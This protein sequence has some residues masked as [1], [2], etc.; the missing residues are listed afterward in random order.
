MSTGTLSEPEQKSPEPVRR[1]VRARRGSKVGVSMLAHGEPMIWLTGAALAICL[2]M[3]VG[4]LGTVI[5]L[6]MGTFTP[7]PVVQLQH[8]DG[9]LIAGEVT[10]REQFPITADLILGQ[11]DKVAGDFLVELVDQLGGAEAV[12]RQLP[13]W[14]AQSQTEMREQIAEFETKVVAVQELIQRNQA[15]IQKRVRDVPNGNGRLQDRLTIIAASREDKKQIGFRNELQALRSKISSLEGQIKNADQ[16]LEYIKT[17]SETPPAE[18]GE[19]A[20]GPLQNLWQ[21]P[22]Q[23][24]VVMLGALLGARARQL[25]RKDVQG[26]RRLVR[27]GNKELS[28]ATFR[29]VMD[30]EIEPEESTEPEWSL[31][32]ERKAWGRF[33]G[34]PQQFVI[35]ELR[36]VGAAEQELQE[37]VQLFE[38]GM[39]DLEPKEQEQLQEPLQGLRDELAA[40]QSKQIKEFL[41]RF[42]GSEGEQLLAVPHLGAPLPVD[43]LQPDTTVVEVRRIW[44]GAAESW[45]RFSDTHGEVLDRSARRHAL[46]KHDSGLVSRRRQDARLALRTQELEID[47]QLKPIYHEKKRVERDLQRLKQDAKSASSAQVAALQQQY[48]ELSEQARQIEA[49]AVN[50]VGVTEEVRQYENLRQ[51]MQAQRD[52]NNAL[53]E[54]VN[55]KFGEDSAMSQA[56]AAIV[57]RRNEDIETAMMDPQAK[58]D[59]LRS[60]L[61]RAPQAAQETIEEF[62]VIQKEADKEN[63]AIQREI[64]LITA[65]NERYELHMLTAD[66]KEKAL[67]LDDI[68]RAY[69][70]NQLNT[71]EKAAVYA[72]RW[73]EFLTADPREANSEGGVFPAIWGTIIMT[74]IMSLAV[75]PFGVLAALYLREYAKAGPIVSAVRISINNLAGVPSIVFGVFGLGFFCYIVGAYV[76]GGPDN[77]VFGSAPSPLWYTFLAALAVVAFVAFACGIGGMAA[78]H[79]QRTVTKIW[80]S[81]ISVLLWL[82]ATALFVLVIATTPFF[83]GFYETQLPNPKFGKGGVFW[84]SLT[85]ALLTLPVVIVATEEALAAVPNSMREGSYGCGASKWQTIRR[86]VLPHA[87]P[88][89]MTGMILAMARG[90]GEV[91]PLMLVG[92][93]KLAP[94]LPIHLA[95]W[96]GSIGP[97]LTGPL[98]ADRSFMHLGFHIFDLGFQSQ[99]S[100]AAKPMVFTTTLLLI[101]IIAL[102]NLGAVWLRNRLR[103]RFQ[104][105]QF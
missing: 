74:L 47:H 99:D 13:Q 38:R 82:V 83:S 101:L 32:V 75:A 41:A 15:E 24:K 55:D 64:D 10:N 76:D 49:N 71:A 93:V 78:H 53:G 62:F 68:V 90:A 67:V 50:L 48:K 59:Q 16:A 73:W 34:Q 11:S 105:G 96:S 61:A 52:R 97:V 25:E 42:D 9:Y 104:E 5:W 27:I 89:I 14:I 39:A 81:R 20:L 58:L 92:A 94:E 54:R 77:T 23:V 84:A 102:L 87:M 57:K 19:V 22:R 2:I 86:I 7:Q 98:H 45:Q 60:E 95:D 6:G 66:E 17:A 103:R 46:M 30:L 33:F 51:A 88:G 40:V 56:A 35:K 79:S 91:A 21:A 26:H 8:K 85:L 37:M 31:V 28:G 72:S 69:P 44:E 36:K 63:A 29:W 70:A 4:L 3:I 80:F 1:K 12:H 100:E 18:G 65:E 43:E